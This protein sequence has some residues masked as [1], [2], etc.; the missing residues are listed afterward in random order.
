MLHLFFSLIIISVKTRSLFQRRNSFQFY[1]AKK[2]NGYSVAIDLI[3]WTGR[4]KH[5]PAERRK[6]RCSPHS[7][8]PTS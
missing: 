2:E 1:T 6:P 4:A 7:K 3:I 5:T 8:M